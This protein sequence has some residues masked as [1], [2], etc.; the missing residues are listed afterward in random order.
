[1]ALAITGITISA[2]FSDKEYGNGSGN[3]MN[4][5]A[6]APDVP[7]ESIDDVISDGLDMYF[8]AWKT[9]LA[10]RFA[11]G[12][13]KADELKQRISDSEQRLA[14]VRKFLRNHPT[15]ETTPSE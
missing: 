7:L 11:T 5:S 14:S 3:F 1:M 6:K 13:I 4:I 15:R 9:L 10:T 2:E 8:A 12:I